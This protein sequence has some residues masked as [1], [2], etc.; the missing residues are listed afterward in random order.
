MSSVPL[1]VAKVPNLNRTLLIVNNKFNV[2]PKREPLKFIIR[3]FDNWLEFGE[4]TGTREKVWLINPITGQKGLFKYPKVKSD[5]SLTG[6]HWAAKLAEEIGKLVGGME[7]ARIDVGRYNQRIGAISYNILKEN[8]QLIEGVQFIR[9]IYPEYDDK[10]RYDPV[11]GTPYSLQMILQSIE[12]L[13]FKKDFLKVPIFDCL[14]GNTDRHHNNWGIIVNVYTG[15]QRFSPLYDNDSSLCCLEDEREI[16]QILKDRHRYL[17]LLTTKSKSKIGLNNIKRPRHLDMV[18]Y[19]KE[20][21]YDYVKEYIERIGDNITPNSIS[22][23]LNRFGNDI[24]S[25]KFKT[26]LVRFILDRRELI[27]KKEV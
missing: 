9:K 8:E 21:Y 22:T 20:N 7:F 1:E 27:T 11:T 14:I 24:I 13:G 25:D 12:G 6:E 23:L 16:D 5:G 15:E 19:L 3:D 4:G 17:A 18:K 2:S 10:R 26:L